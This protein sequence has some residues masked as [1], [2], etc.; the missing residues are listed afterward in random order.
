MMT[1]W[2]ISKDQVVSLSEPRV[3]DAAVVKAHGKKS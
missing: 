2:T 3:N 1:P